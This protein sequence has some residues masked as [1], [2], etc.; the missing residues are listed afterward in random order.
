MSIV[1][2]PVSYLLYYMMFPLFAVGV[3]CFYSALRM[4]LLFEPPLRHP[5]IARA[6]IHRGACLMFFVLRQLSLI[7]THVGQPHGVVFCDKPSVIVANHPSMLDAMLLVSVVP[8]A[9]CIMKRSLLRVP[10]IRGFARLAGYVPHLEAPEMIADAAEA[11]VSGASLVIFPEGTRS[12]CG[13]V[14]AF[15]RGAAR[16]ALET[17]SPVTVCVINMSPVV[18]GGAGGWLYPPRFPIEYE[19]V[20]VDSIKVGLVTAKPCDQDEVRKQSIQLTRSLEECVRN[21]L[22]LCGT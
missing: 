7:R 3:I 9:V 5:R 8:D 1:W 15:R 11:M 2:R 14:G 20:R 16:I 22:L 21:S 6:F 19:V 12:R 17:G 4:R 18:F 10:I 13:G